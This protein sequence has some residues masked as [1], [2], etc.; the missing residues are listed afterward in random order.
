MLRMAEGFPV[1]SNQR[2][3][4]MIVSYEIAVPLDLEAAGEAAQW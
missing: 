2:P 4:R 3:F 1:P